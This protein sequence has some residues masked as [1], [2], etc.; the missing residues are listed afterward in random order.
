[1][2]VLSRKVNQKILIGENIEILV[3]ELKPGKVKIG[4]VA[5]SEVPIVREEL[6]ESTEEAPQPQ[7]A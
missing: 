7:V 1:M 6:K 4:I 3:T 5:P 2:L